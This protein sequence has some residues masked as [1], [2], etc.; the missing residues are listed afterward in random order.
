MSDSTSTDYSSYGVSNS[1]YWS[2][3]VTFSGLGNGTDFST[4]IDA[5]M[6]VESHSLD[7]MEDW[8]SQWET[9]SEALDELNT[10]LLDLES[11]LGDMDEVSEFLVKTANSTNTSALTVEADSDAKETSHVVEVGKLA[12]SDIWVNTE[13]SFSAMDDVV[14]ASDA[15]MSLVLGGNKVTLD[16]PAG[17][18]LEGLITLVNNSA[19]TRDKI[20]ADAIYDGQNYHFELYSQETGTENAIVVSNCSIP[21]LDPSN[22]VNTQ[23]ATNAQLKV[24][25]YPAGED[26]WLERSSNTVDDIITGLTL[27]LHEASGTPVT[28][29]VGTDEDSILANVQTFLDQVNAIYTAIDTITTVSEDDDGNASGSILTG[30]Y[31]VDMVRQSLKEILSGLASGF[32]WYDATDGTG[33]AYATLSQLGITTDSEE[34]SSTFG[35]LVLDEDEFLAALDD[36]PDQ[37]AQVFSADYEGESQSPNLTYMSCISGLTKAQAHEVDYTI[38]GGKIVSATINGEKANVDGWQIT[39]ASGTDATGLA[40]RVD[41]HS[42]GTYSGDVAIKLGKVGE[43]AAKISELTDPQSGTLTIISDNYSDIMSSID[44]KI[45]YENKRLDLLYQELTRK[46]SSLDALMNTYSSLQ[47]SLESQIASL[48]SS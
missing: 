33:D 7:D 41:N 44:D 28:I 1:S 25:G 11:S 40:V 34:G 19:D 31:G 5:T 45:E 17:T 36:D 13:Y 26:E 14:A 10:M 35:H 46:Y 22:Y 8:R 23:K 30:N 12:K 6:Q 3:R 2:G 18:T 4:I 15:S 27:D 42:D 32:D 29:T 39:G 47:T 37:V 21:G 48:S 43:L 9:K 20:Q 38:E 16:V 24:D